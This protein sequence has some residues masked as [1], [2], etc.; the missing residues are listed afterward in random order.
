MIINDWKF[1]EL[2]QEVQ[3]K[4]PVTEINGTVGSK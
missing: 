3:I 1:F 2:N 4:E